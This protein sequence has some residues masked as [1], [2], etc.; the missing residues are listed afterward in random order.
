MLIAKIKF[1]S[2]LLR[3]SSGNVAATYLIRNFLKE[4]LLSL[5]DLIALRADHCHLLVEAL[6][7]DRIDSG[8][9]LHHLN[10]IG[11]LGSEALVNLRAQGNE[12]A[13]ICLVLTV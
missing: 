12:G 6:Q 3:I 4:V 9:L 5:F 13:L 11:K 7:V 1:N 10:D 2:S 8:N